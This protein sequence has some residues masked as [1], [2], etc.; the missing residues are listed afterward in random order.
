MIST[1]LFLFAMG[2]IHL[3]WKAGWI[4]FQKTIFP[5]ATVLRSKSFLI[6]SPFLCTRK[7]SYTRSPKCSLQLH[8]GMKRVTYLMHSRTEIVIF[9]VKCC[10]FLFVSLFVPILIFPTTSKSSPKGKYFPRCLSQKT[11]RIFTP[12][13]KQFVLVW[14]SHYIE[15]QKQTHAV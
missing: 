6:F 11:G 12:A 5:N 4:F 10:C 8:C 13:R 2:V 1:S 3:F 7:T 14:H 9:P 15:I